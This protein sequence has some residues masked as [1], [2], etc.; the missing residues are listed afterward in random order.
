MLPW[1]EVSVDLIGPWKITVQEE[2]LYFNELTCIDQVSNLVEMIQIQNKTATHIS[3]KF[4]ECWLNRYPRPNVCINDT[5]GEFVGW[6]FQN[7]LT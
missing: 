1:T 6:E 2:D 3:Q 7:K 4:E 5:R